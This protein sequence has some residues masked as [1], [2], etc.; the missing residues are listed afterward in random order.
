M[1]ASLSLNQVIDVL[2]S[3]DCEEDVDEP[4]DNDETTREKLV[5]CLGALDGGPNFNSRFF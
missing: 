1:A 4:N 5:K 2:R 3:S